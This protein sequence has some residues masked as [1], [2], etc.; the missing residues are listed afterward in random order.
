MIST[1]SIRYTTMHRLNDAKP[2]TDSYR[3]ITTVALRKSAPPR[4]R[5]ASG[6]LL[7]LG[8]TQVRL[9]HD[10]VAQDWYLDLVEPDPRSSSSAI[11]LLRTRCHFGS[12]R[13]WFECP[14]CSRRSGVLYRHNGEFRCR[15][16]LGLAYFS[17][18]MNYYSLLP[19]FKYL[20]EFER[21]DPNKCRN[22][23]GKPTRY[24]LR[25]EKL[26]AKVQMGM[27]LLGPKYLSR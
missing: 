13:E 19:T 25:Y 20:M 10:P 12:Y 1:I 2:L 22:Y 17:Q 15:R 6:R 8:G 21:M 26:R 14:G 3:T 5:G 18:R 11:S 4:E 27:T 9:I 16:C 7:T 24:T 23:K